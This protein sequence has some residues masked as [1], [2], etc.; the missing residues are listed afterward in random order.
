MNILT[1]IREFFFPRLCVACGTRLLQDEKGVCLRCSI[2]LPHTRLYNREN[3]MEKYFWGR[4]P[5]GRASSLFYYKKK[6]DVAQILYAMKYHGQKQ[7]CIEMGRQLAEELLPYSFFDDIDYLIPVPLHRSR[8]HSRGYN[9][10][11]LLAKGVSQK[12]GIPMLTNAIVRARN[13]TTQTHKGSFAR[14]ENTKELFGKDKNCPN[15]E[16]KHVLL[17]DDV[18]TTGATLT[19][20][21][22][23][24]ADISG[25]RIS[26]LTLAWAK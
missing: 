11:E 18:L 2:K 24:I 10:S 22:D 13:N 9:Q 23:A 4:F 17:I 16:N 25:I 19:S 1:D 12:T 6:G 8:L 21:A 14:W 3:E 15:I 5:I 20:C 7:L 26:I